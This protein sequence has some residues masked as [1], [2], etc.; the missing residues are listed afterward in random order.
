MVRLKKYVTQLL[1]KLNTFYSED[2]FVV[3]T[4]QFVKALL[5]GQHTLKPYFW[6]THNEGHT[7]RTTTNEGR[8]DMTT[9]NEGRT[10][11]T[12]HNEGNTVRTTHNE[13]HTVRTTHNEGHTLLTLC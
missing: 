8:T 6:T 2:H 9:H 7:V 11:R 3:H 4:V 10:V 1:K 12:T 5:F 13:G